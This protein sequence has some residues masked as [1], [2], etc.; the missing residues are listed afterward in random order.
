L[1]DATNPA[2][3]AWYWEK[4]RDNVL[5]RGFDYPWLDANE[6]N[7]TADGL[8]YSIGSGDRYRNIYPLLH[9]EGVAEGLRKWRPRQRVLIL[10]RSAYLGS[11][12]TGALFWSSDVHSTWEALERQIPTGLNM[13]AS[14][15]AYWGSD[16][17]GWLPFPATSSATRPPLIDPSDARDAVGQNHD[18]PEL[19]TRW[20]Q[21]GVFSPT[22]RLHGLRRVNEMWS[23]GKGAE[24]IMA[25]YNR[26]RYRLMPYIYSLAKQTH[27]R[28]APFMRPLWMDF[29]GDPKVANM[30]TQYM[31]G[32]AFL[33]APVTQQ[34]QTEKDVYLPAG[35]DWY[36]YWTRQKYSGG[37]WVKVASP[38]AQI[39][40]FVR[41]GSIIPIGS[42]VQSTADKQDIAFID[43]YPGRDGSFSL[44]DDDGTS[45]DYELG[46]GTRVMRLDWDNK[47]AKLSVTGEN[48]QPKLLSAD[49][50]VIQQK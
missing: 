18:Y 23:F 42:D 34:G 28:G 24:A 25:D 7:L 9:V 11:Q 27:D 43:V 6:P 36:D 31:F 44:Y 48:G 19:I 21:Q 45:Y 15:I 22:L 14:G 16:I 32:P 38:I 40:L 39:P 10:S 49:I 2:A 50:R 29:P 30:G 5:A 26:L 46:K 12:R 35:A 1:I 33:V 17:G 4:I 8:F 3:R 41:A 37:Q 13:S 20:F 47:A